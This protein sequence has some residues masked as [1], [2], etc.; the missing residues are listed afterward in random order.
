MLFDGLIPV[1]NTFLVLL[2]VRLSVH[3][4]GD[5]L[6][7]YQ[8]GVRIGLLYLFIELDIVYLWIFHDD[9][10]FGEGDDCED[11]DDIDP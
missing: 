1:D 9:V 6:C 2:V 4:D 11:D 5:W 7:S 10:L 8:D 3:I